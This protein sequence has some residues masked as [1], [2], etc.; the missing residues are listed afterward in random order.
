MSA[1]LKFD[2]AR[3][4]SATEKRKTWLDEIVKSE[5]EA[6]EEI[7]AYARELAEQ[8]ERVAAVTEHARKLGEH[9]V[10]LLEQTEERERNL[11]ELEERFN[12]L[13]ESWRRDTRRL[14][15]VTQMSLH[16]AY[17]KIIGMGWSAVPLILCEMQGRGGHWLWALHAITDE[18]PAPEG[19]TFHE[20]VQAWLEWGRK[21]NYLT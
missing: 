19:A 7:Q 14:S 9:A 3:G 4:R 8:Y 21:H 15:S 2:P 13:V 1:V 18:D 11:V 20:A 6:R 5:K 12:R 16:P 17:Q 10:T